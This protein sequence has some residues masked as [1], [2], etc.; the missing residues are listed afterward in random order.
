[1]TSLLISPL[2]VTDR[3]RSV[4]SAS[5]LLWFLVLFLSSSCTHRDLDSLAVSA[6]SGPSKESW[7]VEI[8]LSQ[9]DS[10]FDESL[11]R[12]RISADHVQWF[13]EGDSTLQRLQSLQK[14]VEVTIYDSS[15]AFSALLEADRVSY[16]KE[17]EY[18]IAKGDVL[19]ETKD[20]RTL[21]TERIEWLEQDQLLRTDRFVHITTPEEV[22][23]GMGLEAKEDLRSYQIGQFRAQIM[24]DS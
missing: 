7:D 12:L 24:V 17:R 21:V 9:A 2:H 13:G 11:T 23:T 4:G 8:V 10:E 16:F 15:G 19:I 22:V 3:R 14:K 6:P 18:F 1:M 5:A 20:N